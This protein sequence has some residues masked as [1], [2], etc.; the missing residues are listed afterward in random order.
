MCVHPMKKTLVVAE[1][2]VS[3]LFVLEDRYIS[4]RSILLRVTS[5]MICKV[6]ALARCLR[7]LSLW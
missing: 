5:V 3:V 6:E 4:G 7:L 1:R 2:R